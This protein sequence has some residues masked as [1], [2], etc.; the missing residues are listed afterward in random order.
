MTA[1]YQRKDGRV[2]DNVDSAYVEPGTLEWREYQ[3]YLAGDNPLMRDITPPKER[4][5]SKSK[6]EQK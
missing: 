2:Y 3:A 4:K 1:R 6:K 5:R